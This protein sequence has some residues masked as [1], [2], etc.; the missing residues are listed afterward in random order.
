MARPADRAVLLL[1]RPVPDASAVENV[2]AF[3]HYRFLGFE[4]LQANRA[5]NVFTL[6]DKRFVSLI[7]FTVLFVIDDFVLITW[8]DPDIRILILIDFYWGYWR[9]SRISPFSQAVNKGDVDRD[10]NTDKDY[11]DSSLVL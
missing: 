2:T 7:D 6:D 1:H 10:E 9:V 3:Q 4:M 8:I 5:G 11:E